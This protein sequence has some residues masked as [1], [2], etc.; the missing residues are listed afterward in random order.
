MRRVITGALGR[1]PGLMRKTLSSPLQVCGG[2][3]VGIATWQAR[4]GDPE[5]DLSLVCIS[6]IL[7]S[8]GKEHDYAMGMI[9]LALNIQQQ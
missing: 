8:V 1:N 2:R 3:E 9:V 7:G 5:T 6:R 4:I